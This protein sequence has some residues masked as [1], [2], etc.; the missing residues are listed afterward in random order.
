MPGGAG[1]GLPDTPEAGD[2]VG[3]VLATGDINQDGYDDLVVGV[4]LEDYLAPGLFVHQNS[5][6]IA[7]SAQPG[8]RFGVALP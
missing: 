5:P 3:S 4:P 2:R 1:D 6:G 7:E 8:D